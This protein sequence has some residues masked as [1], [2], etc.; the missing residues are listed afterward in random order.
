MS[1]ATRRHCSSSILRRMGGQPLKCD[2][3]PIPAYYDPQYGC[4]MEILRFRSWNPNPRFMLWVEEMRHSLQ[5]IP[6]IESTDWALAV[7]G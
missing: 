5:Y 3:I 6:V 7:V 4:E 2:G 1:T